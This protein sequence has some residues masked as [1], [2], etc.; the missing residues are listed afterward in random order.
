MVPIGVNTDVVASR[1]V[2]CCGVSFRDSVTLGGSSAKPREKLS[3]SDAEFDAAWL[4]WI[5]LWRKNCESSYVGGG[6]DELPDGADPD[7]VW[8]P[9]L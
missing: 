6:L 8:Q 4:S 2:D 9:T 5:P 7:V 3:E 1:S